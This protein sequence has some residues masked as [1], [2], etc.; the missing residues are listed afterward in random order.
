MDTSL[1]LRWETAQRYYAVYVHPDLWGEIVLTRAWGGKGSRLGNVQS[2]HIPQDDI[3]KALLDIAHR[4][5]KHKYQPVDCAT[6]EAIDK[7]MAGADTAATSQG[8]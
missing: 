8:A 7:L 6:R 4:R 5:Q 3:T 2:D 1:A